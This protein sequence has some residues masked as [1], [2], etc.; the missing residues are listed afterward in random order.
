MGTHDHRPVYKCPQ[1]P[2]SN[3]TWLRMQLGAPFRWDNSGQGHPPFPCSLGRP[4]AAITLAGL[5]KGS[6]R[7]RS[8]MQ[9]TDRPAWKLG[10]RFVLPAGVLCFLRFPAKHCESPKAS[11]HAASESALWKLG[12]QL[13]DSI[14]KG[15]RHCV[16]PIPRTAPKSHR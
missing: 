7:N 12:L 15:M 8:M 4:P 6:R 5:T 14:M 10:D 3:K 9:F 2:L 13:T 11:L 1:C 16:P